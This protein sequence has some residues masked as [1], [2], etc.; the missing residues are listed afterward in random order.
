MPYKDSERERERHR[1]RAADRRAQGLCIKC[2]KN[3]P[4]LSRTRSLH[5]SRRAGFLKG[6]VVSSLMAPHLLR[7]E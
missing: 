4:A 2:R 3:P 1:K 6:I 7:A 5:S